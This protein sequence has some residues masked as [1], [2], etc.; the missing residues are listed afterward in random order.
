MTGM[1]E[2]TTLCYL[3]KDGKALMLHRV[4]KNNDVNKDKWIGVGG[5]KEQGEDM[6]T[7]MRR[8]IREETGLVV[9]K[10][11]EEGIIDF[12]YPHKEAE[13]ITIYTSSDFHGDITECNEGTLAWIDKNKIPDLSLWE[14]DRIFL[15]RMLNHNPEKFHF[16]FEYDEHDVLRKVKEEKYE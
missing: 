6:E 15:K 9:G 1:P 14:G 11:K 10:L 13:K 7:C 8:E 12:I 16:I 3:V 4:V 5:K 2:L